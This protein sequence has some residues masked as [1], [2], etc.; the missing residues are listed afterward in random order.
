MWLCVGPQPDERGRQGQSRGWCAGAQERGVR[1]TRRTV[2]G[3]PGVARRRWCRHR[4]IE[5]GAAYSRHGPFGN[6]DQRRLPEG[7]PTLLPR[8][9]PLPTTLRPWSVLPGARVQNPLSVKSTRS[10]A[11]RVDAHSQR[12]NAGSPRRSVRVLIKHAGVLPHTASCASRPATPRPEPS[13]VKTGQLLLCYVML[14]YVM[15]S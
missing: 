15:S 10:P 9:W 6:G 14:C 4:T 11:G 7:V 5:R 13:H 8:P 2:I 1:F 3:T 12:C